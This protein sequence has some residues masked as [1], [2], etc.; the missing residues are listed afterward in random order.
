VG[1]Q[2]DEQRIERRPEIDEIEPVPELFPAA[3][4]SGAVQPEEGNV[5]AKEWPYPE[6]CDQA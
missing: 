3:K 6:E 5:I 1:E 4:R 2:R